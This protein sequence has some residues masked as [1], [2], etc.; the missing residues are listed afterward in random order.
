MN[1]YLVR[2]NYSIKYIFTKIPKHPNCLKRLDKISIFEYFQIVEERKNAKL[3]EIVLKEIVDYINS[4]LFENEFS[5]TF[6]NDEKKF[7]FL[8][9]NLNILSDRIEKEKISITDRNFFYQK[10]LYLLYRYFPLKFSNSNVIKYFIL[11]NQIGGMF[12]HIIESEMYK[13]FNKIDLK[14]FSFRKTFGKD[15]NLP[16]EDFKAKLKNYFFVNEK[17]VDNKI[18]EKLYLYVLAH[19]IF[20]NLEKLSIVTDT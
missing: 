9:L 3:E 10:R 14:N 5:N 2:F 12:N 4:S 1:K 20:F 13:K 17:E 16:E 8:L 19:V 6:A 15:I 11:Q 18:I 7:K